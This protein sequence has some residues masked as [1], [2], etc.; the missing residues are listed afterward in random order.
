ML[1]LTTRNDAKQREMTCGYATGV[2]GINTQLLPR[3]G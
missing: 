2:D 1:N 3:M